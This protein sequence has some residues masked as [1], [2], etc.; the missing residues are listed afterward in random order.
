MVQIPLAPKIITNSDV[1][2]CDGG[3]L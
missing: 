3:F 1:N 2:R